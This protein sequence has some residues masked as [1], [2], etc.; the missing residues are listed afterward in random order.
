MQVHSYAGWLFTAPTVNAAAT[1]RRPNIISD[2]LQHFMA[3]D[4]LIRTCMAGSLAL[5]VVMAIKL[6]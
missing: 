1:R 3:F 4:L 5:M 2:P 6:D